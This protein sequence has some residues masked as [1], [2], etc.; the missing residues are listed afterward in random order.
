MSFKS[1]GDGNS[2]GPGGA[3]SE[4]WAESMQ[5]AAEVIGV[6]DGGK[7]QWAGS[8]SNVQHPITQPSVPVACH[9][10]LF[11]PISAGIGN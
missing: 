4:S 2:D 3:L 8:I 7:G 9:L 10:V 1:L 11:M 6:E 5:Y